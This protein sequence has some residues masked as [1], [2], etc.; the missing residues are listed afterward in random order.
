[1]LTIKWIWSTTLFSM[2]GF[3]LKTN[4]IKK[5]QQQK[6]SETISIPDIAENR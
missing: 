1:M 4:R 5:K 6:I 2:D 3:Q